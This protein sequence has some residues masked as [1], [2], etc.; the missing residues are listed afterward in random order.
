MTIRPVGAELQIQ[1]KGRTDGR[2]E[3]GQ[4][5]RHNGANSRFSQLCERT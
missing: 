3:D 4:T 5:E 2:T 1:M